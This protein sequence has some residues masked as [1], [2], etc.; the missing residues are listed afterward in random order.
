[1]K[2]IGQRGIQAAVT[3]QALVSSN[4]KQQLG[5]ILSPLM[6]VLTSTVKLSTDS[7]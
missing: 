6:D 7:T 1:M 3:S 4:Y 5:I 2:Y